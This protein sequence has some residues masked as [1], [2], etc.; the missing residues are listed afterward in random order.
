MQRLGGIETFRCL[1]SSIRK[2][3]G[4]EKGGFCFSSIKVGLTEILFYTDIDRSLVS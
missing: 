3:K 4:F 2:V 1:F